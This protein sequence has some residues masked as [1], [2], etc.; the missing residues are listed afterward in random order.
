MECNRIPNGINW[1]DISGDQLDEYRNHLESC[2]ICRLRVFREAP[3]Q[4][5]FDIRQPELPEDFWL[6]FWGS[7]ESKLSRPESSTYSGGKFL[8]A[9]WAAVFVIALLVTLYSRQVHDEPSPVPVVNSILPTPDSSAYPL[10]EEVQNPNSRYYIF[11]PQGNENIV[12]VFNPDME[13]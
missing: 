10:V 1:D 7:V 3:E 4:L 6:G 12:M 9:R 13:L 11:Q 8:L 2:P 5:L